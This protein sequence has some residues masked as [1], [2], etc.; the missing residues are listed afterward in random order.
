MCVRCLHLGYCHGLGLIRKFT[1]LIF[2]R[3]TKGVK[4][5][6]RETF[7]VESSTLIISTVHCI[8]RRCKDR[9]LFSGVPLR[10]VQTHTSKCRTQVSGLLLCFSVSWY[11]NPTS[12]NLPEVPNICPLRTPLRGFLLP[13]STHV[14]SRH[15]GN[16]RVQLLRSPSYSSLD[17]FSVNTFFDK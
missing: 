13:S 6:C 5:F 2:E 3:F 4:T 12:S 8:S 15:I 14:E 17:G 9:Y 1:Q 10:R 16:F 11:L 7:E